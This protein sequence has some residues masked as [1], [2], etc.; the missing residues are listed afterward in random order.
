MSATFPFVDPFIR[1]E[2][3]LWGVFHCRG[4]K[5]V[6]VLT[7][8]WEIWSLQ[9]TLHRQAITLRRALLKVVVLRI[10][11]AVNLRCLPIGYLHTLLQF[12]HSIIS[13]NVLLQHFTKK[14]D[15]ASTIDQIQYRFSEF[16]SGWK[17]CINLCEILSF[18]LITSQEFAIDGLDFNAL[19]D[20]TGGLS[21]AD[22][23]T[24]SVVP[25]VSTKARS[26][27]RFETK[28]E[29]YQPTIAKNAVNED[30]PHDKF[31]LKTLEEHRHATR[32]QEKRVTSK[33]WRSALREAHKLIESEDRVN[34]ASALYL[35][36]EIIWLDPRGCNLATMYLDSGSI[37]LAFDHLEEAAKA[38]RNCLRLDG[39][40][41]KARY[42][43]G[44]ATARLQD[45][46]ETTRQL[47]LA[48][49]ACP[50]D[51][52]EEIVAILQEIDRIQSLKNLRA[53]KEATK[54]RVF[55]TQYLESQHLITGK[56]GVPDL[57]ED[58]TVSHRN[59]MALSSSTPHL[60]DV[61]HEWQGAL[62][63]VLHRLHAFARCRHI[64]VQDEMLRQDPTR[65]GG[66]SVQ[67]LAEVVTR[68]TGIPLGV[69]EYNELTLM[70]GHHGATTFHYLNPNVESSHAFDEIQDHDTNHSQERS[71]HEAAFLED[72]HTR[73]ARETL[74]DQQVARE[75]LL[76]I[77]DMVDDVIINHRHQQKKYDDEVQWQEIPV[78]TEQRQ[79]IMS[80]VV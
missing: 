76:R 30:C 18:S 41:W 5:S 67:A 31:R 62:A 7:N 29:Q 71:V 12:L 1:L 23:G 44:V 25:V 10:L 68:I 57:Q 78:R 24:C 47:K 43:L 56:L 4:N 6:V 36:L 38:Y 27:T 19:Q 79:K 11:R 46:V 61:S 33:T 39:S 51:I 73:L 3:A 42:N 52:A 66:I 72:V 20:P 17:L 45:F 13:G 65:T 53:Y 35:L 9:P 37:Y 64:N 80:D 69:T 54:A 55:T 16:T 26:T 74:L 8:L 40:N 70:L 75:V 59:G 63:S 48:L 2:N 77:E 15:A 28:R 58:H 21:V 49:K 50:A 14:L 34:L 22:D 32:F 60:L